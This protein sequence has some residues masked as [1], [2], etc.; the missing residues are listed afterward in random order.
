MNLPN[1]IAI[2]QNADHRSIARFSSEHDRNYRPVL[3][4]LRLF[5]DDIAQDL[6][7]SL[8]NIS[9]LQLATAKRKYIG[10]RILYPVFTES[11]VTDVSVESCVPFEIPYLLRETFRGRKDVLDQME[12][13]FY[14]S[15][16]KAE[17]GQ[18][19]FAICGLGMYPV[20]LLQLDSLI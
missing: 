18:L 11:Y 6:E 19:S 1:E 17:P 14:P 13:H 15:D 5:R 3:S 8:P 7:I 16:G 9:E 12:E 2:G 20:S 4:R 10:P